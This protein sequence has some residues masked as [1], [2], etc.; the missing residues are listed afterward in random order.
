[1]L[2]V[3]LVDGDKGGV[4]KSI[5]A[6]LLIHYHVTLP[7]EVRPSIYVIDSDRSNPDIGGT[8]GYVEDPQAGIAAVALLDLSDE[9]GWIDL[10]KRFGEFVEDENEHRVIVSL[11]SQIGT[12]A[13][14]GE[15]AIVREAMRALNMIPVWVRSRTKECLAALE[16]RQIALPHRYDRGVAVRNLFWGRAREFYRLENSELRKSLMSSGWADVT[17][18][19]INETVL[20]GI[21]RAP[22]HTIIPPDGHKVLDLGT[23]MSLRASVGAAMPSMKVIADYSPTGEEDAE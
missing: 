20:D 6:R 14:S 19:A 5:A 21:E 15:I 11:P 3:F 9:D 8:G 10:V 23:D 7:A 17:L 16:G 12:R 1:M 2:K 13:F 18:P 22:L 4:G